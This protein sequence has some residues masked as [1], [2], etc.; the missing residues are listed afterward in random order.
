ML[1]RSSLLLNIHYTQQ[2]QTKVKTITQSKT[3][4]AFSPCLFP[5]HKK[6]AKHLI[7]NKIL[8]QIH[9]I[10][11][12]HILINVERAVARPARTS[13]GNVFRL[14]L[15]PTKKLSESRVHDVLS[16]TLETNNLVGC[17]G[18]R[19]HIPMLVRAG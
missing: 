17:R 7:P 8:S 19:N 3:S 16:C 6:Q 5:Y 9:S 14:L 10:N 2:I 12:I 13:T 18:N 11:N 1:I 4:N 15:L